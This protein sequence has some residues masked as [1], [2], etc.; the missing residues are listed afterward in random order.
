MTL[1][2]LIKEIK[3]ETL[4]KE[5]LEK[6]FDQITYLYCTMNERMAECEKAEALYIV[7]HKTKDS[8]DIAIRREWNVTEMGQEAFTLKRNIKSVEKLL[9]SIKSRIYRLL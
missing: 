9:S 6:Y 7:E 2:T 4:P 5:S 8:T 1:E 3:E